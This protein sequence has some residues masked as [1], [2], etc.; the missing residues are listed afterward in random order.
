VYEKFTKHFEEQM[1]DIDDMTLEKE[2]KKLIQLQNKNNE[3]FYLYSFY[4][5]LIYS[6]KSA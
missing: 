4:F 3:L 6:H 1:V 2:H 5:Y